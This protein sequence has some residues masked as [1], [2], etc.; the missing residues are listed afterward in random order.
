MLHKC[1]ELAVARYAYN[2]LAPVF[3][4]YN[5]KRSFIRI[6]ISIQTDRGVWFY[7]CYCFYMSVN[8]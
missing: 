7:N 1:L 6:Y 5:Y 3:S 2:T 4:S 8:F